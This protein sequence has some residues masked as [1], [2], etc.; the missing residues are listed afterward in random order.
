MVYGELTKPW[1]VCAIALV[2]GG[3]TYWA[4]KDPGISLVSAGLWASGTYIVNKGF[5]KTAGFL[6]R[7]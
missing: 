3:A 7:E 6:G 1:T 5:E 2:S 4:S